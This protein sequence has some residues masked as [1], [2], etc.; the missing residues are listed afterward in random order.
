MVVAAFLEKDLFF[1]GL[2]GTIGT[3][4]TNPTWNSVGALIGAGGVVLSV[5]TLIEGAV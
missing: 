3:M 5:R 1:N 4:G 2:L